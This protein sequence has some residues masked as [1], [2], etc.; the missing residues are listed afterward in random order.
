VWRRL[1]AEGADALEVDAL[2][3][4]LQRLR[5]APAKAWRAG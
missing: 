3:L 4:A 5:R 2:I 1:S